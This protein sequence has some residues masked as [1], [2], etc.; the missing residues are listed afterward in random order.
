[1][2]YTLTILAALERNSAN[3]LST[4]P[5]YIH[6]SGIGIISDNCR[7]EYVPLEQIRYYTDMDG[8]SLADCLS[9]NLHLENDK[10]IIAAGTRKENPIRTIIV[11]PS[12]VYGISEGHNRMGVIHVKDW[13][14]AILTVFKAASEGKADEGA[15]GLYF[16]ISDEPRLDMKT[17]IEEMGDGILPEGSKPLSKEALDSSRQ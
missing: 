10:V 1:M 13:A 11:L 17:I 3:N 12:W 4:P 8:F 7:D 16:A 5:L 9:N 15:E 2:F 14:A 6:I